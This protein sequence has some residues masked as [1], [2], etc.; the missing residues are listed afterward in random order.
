MR[1]RLSTS[2]WQWRASDREESGINTLGP[3]LSCIAAAVAA[4]SPYMRSGPVAARTIMWLC[5]RILAHY[6]DGIWPTSGMLWVARRHALTRRPTLDG[7]AEAVGLAP[8]LDDVR[9]IGEPVDKCFAEPRVWDHR[10]P[11][12]ERQVGGHDHRR[13]LR[14]VGNDLEDQLAGDFGERHVAEFVDADQVEPRPFAK[15][16]AE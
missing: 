3:G 10:R 16:A 5:Q 1:V 7:A 14:P 8:G 9:L 12:R 11:F 6:A 13:F 15:H 2:L 4:T